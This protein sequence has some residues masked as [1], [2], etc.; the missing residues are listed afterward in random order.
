MFNC[1]PY[2][3]KFDDVFYQEAFFYPKDMNNGVVIIMMCLDGEIKESGRMK[4]RCT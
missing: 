3:Q 1:G 4:P 2:F